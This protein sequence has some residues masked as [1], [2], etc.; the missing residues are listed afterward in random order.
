[1]GNPPY[2]VGEAD[3]FFLLYSF[4]FILSSLFFKKPG[5]ENPRLIS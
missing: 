4:F 5:G 2:F 1:V 3:T